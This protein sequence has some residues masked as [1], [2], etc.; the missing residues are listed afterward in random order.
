MLF[1]EVNNIN[2]DFANH[3][4]LKK[5]KKIPETAMMVGHDYFVYLF[6]KDKLKKKFLKYCLR[7]GAL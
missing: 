4:F 1:D 6:Q 5:T 3:V 7:V 2:L